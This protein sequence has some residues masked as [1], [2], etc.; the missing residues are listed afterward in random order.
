[1]Y[2]PMETMT[3]SSDCPASLSRNGL[4]PSVVDEGYMEVKSPQSFQ[5]QTTP[6]QED[7]KKRKN[8]SKELYAI[9]FSPTDR[10]TGEDREKYS[11]LWENGPGGRES[12]FSQDSAFDSS[13]PY[14][15]LPMNSRRLKKLNV[16]LPRNA[17]SNMSGYSRLDL[18]RE[19]IL[20]RSGV[21]LR[22][23]NQGE[24]VSSILSAFSQPE[25]SLEDG[26]DGSSGEGGASTD[27]GLE[28]VNQ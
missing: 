8:S 16:T 4:L 25:K 9:P 7:L 15:D 28:P 11:H 19:A 22:R 6:S 2:Y 27:D 18:S 20:L 23:Y 3:P 17:P 24:S 13:Q 10:D 21:T 26:S 1:M 14:Y 12:P 5:R